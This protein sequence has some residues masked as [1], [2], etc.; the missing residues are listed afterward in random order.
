MAS[1]YS[2]SGLHALR[3]LTSLFMYKL[4]NKDRHNSNEDV[5]CE[6]PPWDHLHENQ[7]SSGVYC[8]GLRKSAYRTIL[9]QHLST[10][11][12]ET[13]GKEG[14]KFLTQEILDDLLEALTKVIYEVETDQDTSEPEEGLVNIG[15]SFIAHTQSP[16]VVQPRQG[17][18]DHP[19][20]FTKAAAVCHTKEQSCVSCG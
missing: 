3:Q 18:L 8:Y 9:E 16:E 6:V 11:E 19:A 7:Y 1:Y 13:V 15:A 12:W 14:E 17:T 2:V 4:A 10:I 5:Q 20:R